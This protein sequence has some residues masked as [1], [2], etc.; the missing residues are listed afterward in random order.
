M[1]RKQRGSNGQGQ[2]RGV[3]WWRQRGGVGGARGSR[4]VSRVCGVAGAPP[5]FQRGGDG[6]MGAW[7]HLEGLQL[8]PPIQRSPDTIADVAFAKIHGRDGGR[9]RSEV[10]HEL[11]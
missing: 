4:L 5:P 1:R 10:C 9:Q 7:S 3:R 11:S 6:R 2:G 8:P